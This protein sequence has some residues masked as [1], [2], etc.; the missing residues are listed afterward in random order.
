[1]GEAAICKIGVLKVSVGSATASKDT[2]GQ[3]LVIG[4]STTGD[5][6]SCQ[7]RFTPSAH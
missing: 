5:I 6:S 3:K 4:A 2:E 7:W 1:M